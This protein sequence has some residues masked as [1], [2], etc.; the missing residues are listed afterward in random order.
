MKI[1]Q[2]VTLISLLTVGVTS[3]LLSMEGDPSSVD[4]TGEVSLLSIRPASPAE[5]PDLNS[6]PPPKRIK[7]PASRTIAQSTI[8]YFV[9]LK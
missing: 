2:T 3:P 1:L 5:S 8:C 6:P 4:L 9:F 7:D